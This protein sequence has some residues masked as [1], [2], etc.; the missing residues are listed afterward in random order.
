[1]L[2]FNSRFLPALLGGALIACGCQSTA[3]LP[4]TTQVVANG[5]GQM[6]LNRTA[7]RGVMQPSVLLKVTPTS[8]TFKKHK[9]QQAYMSPNRDQYSE[10]DNCKG[11]ATAQYF[12]YGIWT[13]TPGTKN[14]KCTITFKDT[15]NGGTAKM[16]VINKSN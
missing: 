3:S 11:I 6:S 5:T 7:Q 2:P 4:V 16:K 10:T 12:D 15:V 9:T 14:A 13:I 1:V 8:M